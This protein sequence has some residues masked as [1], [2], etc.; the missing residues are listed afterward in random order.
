M[1]KCNPTQ[2]VGNTAD[3][4]ALIVWSWLFYSFHPWRRSLTSKHMKGRLKTWIWVQ[5]TRW[6]IDTSWCV[7]MSIL[8]ILLLTITNDQHVFMQHLVTVGRNFSCSVWS[9][10]QLAMG[11][12]WLETKP[13]IPEKTFR[14]MACR[15]EQTKQKQLKN[16][17]LWK[18]IPAVEWFYFH[19]F[20]VWK[21]RRPKRCPEAVHS[22][23][24]P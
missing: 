10:N 12:K 20:Q 5:G 17:L 9:G 24:P 23:D 4:L 19:V 15:Y 13:Q 21:G 7:N 3:V 16:L 2:S 1:D 14:Y 22:P 6:N 8:L 18:G 11:L